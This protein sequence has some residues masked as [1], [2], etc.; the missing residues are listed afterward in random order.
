MR[1]D[2]NGCWLV[3]GGLEGVA[4]RLYDFEGKKLLERALDEAPR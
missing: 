2:E 1:C 4:L 3:T